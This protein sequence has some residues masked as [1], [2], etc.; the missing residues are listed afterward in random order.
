MSCPLCR[1]ILKNKKIPDKPIIID[2]NQML[3]SI[4]ETIYIPSLD[5]IDD[6]E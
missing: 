2:H 6:E 1:T 4:L 3:L 5:D